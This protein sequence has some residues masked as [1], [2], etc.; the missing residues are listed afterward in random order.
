MKNLI[1]MV[2]AVALALSGPFVLV[3]CG[4]GTMPLTNGGGGSNGGGDVN[5][6]VRQKIID[7]VQNGFSTHQT[8][9]G[10]GRK[11]TTRG[12][13]PIP[14][15]YF[16]AFYELWVQRSNDF[17]G[18]KC[19]ED[20]ACTRP[21]GYFRDD[22]VYDE[23]GSDFEA[24]ASFE[25]TK[26]PK[27]GAKGTSYTSLK[28]SPNFLLIM[29]SEGNI[30]GFASYSTS[31]RWDTNGG[32]YKSYSKDQNG[33]IQR[34]ET[35]YNTDGTSMLLFT[36]ENALEFTLNF[37]ADQSGKGTIT[38]DDKTLL[39]ADIVWDETGSGTITFKDGSTATF[40]NFQ[41]RRG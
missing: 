20:E 24:N 23:L 8:G 10:S 36:D 19:Y 35:S 31:G 7:A 30:P 3:G 21:A 29:S 22:R 33:L 12:E 40:D 32:V 11:R 34:Y 16:D 17:D 14:T 37:N 18:L 13:D 9:K 26:G 25:I 6:S 28:T 41:F 38:G 4:G 39:P 15:V 1:G 5:R 2:C 27:A